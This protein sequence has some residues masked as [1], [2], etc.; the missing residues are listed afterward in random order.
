[1]RISSFSFLLL[2][3]VTLSAFTI[4]APTS[5]D[6]T[7]SKPR[8]KGG[9]IVVRHS[10]RISYDEVQ[11]PGVQIFVGNVEFYHDGV[12]LRCDS[13]NF[14]QTSNSFAA[15]DHV[16]LLQGDTLSLNC[17]YIFYDGNSQVAQARYNVVLRH[18]KTTLYTDS[19]DYD[20]LYSMGY[21]FEGGRLVDGTTTLTSDWGQYDAL[22]R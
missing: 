18:R 20:R 10:D 22:T 1:M 5:K 8:P 11:M 9:D 13:A 3:A 17:D 14:F 12:I 16:R 15:F 21:F 7:L 19:L 4:A 6:K 2:I